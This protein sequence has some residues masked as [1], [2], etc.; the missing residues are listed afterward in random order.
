LVRAIRRIG[1]L[2]ND[3][4]FQMATDRRVRDVV[5]RDVLARVSSDSRFSIE[6]IKRVGD[7][8]LP[9]KLLE[10]GLRDLIALEPDQVGE[11]E[12]ML[13]ERNPE[14]RYAALGILDEAYL[15]RSKILP[16]L[17]KL[18]T[19]ANDDVRQHVLWIAN[20]KFPGAR[21]TV[22]SS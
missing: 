11:I 20:N 7:G 2:S 1:P 17:D 3:Q 16:W 12:K 5:E 13:L 14:L 22:T 4:L 8:T 9:A 21:Q 18:D 15:D 10:N 6:F 19:D